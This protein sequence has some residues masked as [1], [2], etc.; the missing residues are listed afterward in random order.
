MKRQRVDLFE[1]YAHCCRICPLDFFIALKIKNIL[2]S[3]V[4]TPEIRSGVRLERRVV[5][6]LVSQRHPQWLAAGL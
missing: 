5:A 2:N 3:N 1:A 6:S 4:Q